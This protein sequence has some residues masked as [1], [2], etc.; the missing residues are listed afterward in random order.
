MKTRILTRRTTQGCEK[1]SRRLGEHGEDGFLSG[2]ALGINPGRVS[3][4]RGGTRATIGTVPLIQQSTPT[5]VKD[6]EKIIANPPR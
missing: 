6:E 4:A 2:P 3:Q 1:V 5:R